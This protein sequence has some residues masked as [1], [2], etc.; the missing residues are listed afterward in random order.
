MTNENMA[1]PGKDSVADFDGQKYRTVSAHQQEWG[2]KLIAE[3]RLRGE[4]RILDIGCGDGRLSAQL[5][6]LVPQG[7]VLGIDASP[8]MIDA[9][10][11]FQGRNLSFTLMNINNANFANEFDIVFSNAALHYVKN[12]TLLLRIVH[13]SLKDEGLFRGNFAG[14]GNC[15]AWLNV[16]KELM[17]SPEFSSAFSNFEWPYFMPTIECYQGL[18]SESPF[19]DAEI[20]PEN[21]DRYFPNTT[22]MLG[23]LEQPSIVPFKQHLSKPMAERFHQLAAQRML[24]L[25]TQPDGTCFENFRRINILAKK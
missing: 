9:A 12:H 1:F 15:R 21:A 3:L 16:A 13:R 2:S 11:S 7:H 6:K 18:A 8:G 23:W 17:A 19:S 5:A 14:D 10:R 20:W 25:T 22:A 4:E 24:E